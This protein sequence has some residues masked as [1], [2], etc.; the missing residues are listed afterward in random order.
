MRSSFLV[1]GLLAISRIMWP[2]LKYSAQILW[3]IVKHYVAKF[4]LHLT[5]SDAAVVEMIRRRQLNH[6]QDQKAGSLSNSDN[7]IHLKRLK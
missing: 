5:R 1:M 7:V 3:D 4:W 6:H 2:A